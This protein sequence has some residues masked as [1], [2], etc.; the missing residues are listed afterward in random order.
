MI[1]EETTRQLKVGRLI[2]K[3][4]SL[5]FQKEASQIPIGAMLTVTKVRVSPDLS[6]AKVYLSVFPSSKGEAMI[7]KVTAAQK[8]LRMYLGKR[9]KTQLRI[10]PGL[11]F[12]IDDSIEYYE[13]I[14]SLLKDDSSK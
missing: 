4:L 10:V 14:D 7:A 6:Y 3:E 1:K 8:Q 5:I 13:N 9:V 12:F 2:Q 11:S